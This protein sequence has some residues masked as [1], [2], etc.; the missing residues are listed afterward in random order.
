MD[1]ETFMSLVRQ[2]VSNSDNAYYVLY[3][4]ATCLLT[5]LLKKIFVNKIKVDVLHKFDF[6]VIIPYIVGFAFAVVDVYLVHG[7]RA[8]NLSIVFKIIIGAIT[9]GALASTMFKLVKSVFG[10][11]LSSLMK[12]EVFSVFY[13][14]LLYFG[15][16][17]QQLIDK[18]LTLQ[19]FI[20]QVKLISANATSIYQTDANVDTKRCQLARLLGG[21]IDEQSIG[22]CINLLN[23]MLV[24]YTANK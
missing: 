10:Q 13:T 15:N 23:D 16:V 4:V 11:S 2:Y 14:Q 19:D 9:I 22:V 24:A 3:A 7:I 8:F 21:I 5:Q 6:S 17:R 1:F 20:E 12:D 18:T